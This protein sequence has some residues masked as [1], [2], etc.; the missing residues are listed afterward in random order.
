VNSRKVTIAKGELDIVVW[1][2]SWGSGVVEGHGEGASTQDR[3]SAGC[4]V[5]L[6]VSYRRMCRAQ[7]AT[8]IDASTAAW[9]ARLRRDQNLVGCLDAGSQERKMRS[10]LVLQVPAS[11]SRAKGDQY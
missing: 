8:S 9:S 4:A 11:V 2:Q 7:Q 5:D 1:L 10:R 6:S 3:R